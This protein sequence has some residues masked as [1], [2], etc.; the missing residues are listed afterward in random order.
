MK[1]HHRFHL[2]LSKHHEHSLCL[3]TLMSFHSS[4]HMYCFEGK[5]YS[6]DPSTEDQKSFDRLLEEQLDEFQRTAGEGRALR[7]KAGVRLSP[8]LQSDRNMLNWAD[9]EPCCC[10]CCCCLFR[11]CTKSWM[12]GKCLVFNQY[13]FKVEGYAYI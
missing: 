7:H 4:D 8:S 1:I 6:K 9:K 5:D 2:Y 12:F 10:C 3:L 13:V 11:V